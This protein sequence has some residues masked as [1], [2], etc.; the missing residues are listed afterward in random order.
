MFYSLLYPLSEEIGFFNL[1]RY[2]SFRMVAAALTALVLALWLFPWAIEKLRSLGTQPIREDGVQEHLETKAKTPTAGGT[3]VISAVLLS[4][5]LWGDLTN[6]YVLGTLAIMIGFGLV[7]WYD[8]YRKMKYRD[9]KGLSGKLRLAIE[10][11]ITFAVIAWL[12]QGEAQLSTQLD[13][14]FT[15]AYRPDMGLI[16]MVLI[17]GFITVGTANACNLTDGLDGLAIGPVIVSAAVLLVLAYIAGTPMGLVT[18][19]CSEA[20]AATGL[21]T[22]GTPSKATVFAD[23]LMIIRVPG[24]EEAAVVAAA[25]MGAGLSFLWFNAHPAEIF[26]G[27][28]GSLGLGGVLG[29]LAVAT[30]K[31]LFSAVLHGLFLFNALSVIIQVFWYKR[32]G[33]RV[34]R[35]APFHHHLELAGWKE[36]KVVVRW[37]ILS[38]MLALLSIALLKVR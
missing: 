18:E 30:K 29:I 12:V 9:P 27:D 35:M 32:T 17:G 10:F 25:V 36:T 33:K 5:L 26:M 15:P 4:V 13:L 14:P 7:G 1:F 28:T 19:W 34:F 6:S 38:I 22:L 16:G 21:C 24:V 8:D 20:Q 2:T 23:Y 11:A 31:E 3:V 37:W